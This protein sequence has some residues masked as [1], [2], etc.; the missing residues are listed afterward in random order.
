MTPLEHVCND[1]GQD[2]SLCPEPCGRNH[3]FCS[4]CGRQADPCVHEIPEGTAWK[5]TT[6]SG[7]VHLFEFDQ[8]GNATV[9]RMAGDGAGGLR[10]DG[11]PVPLLMPPAILVGW[12]M[13]MVLDVRGDGVVTERTTTP[14]VS[15]EVIDRA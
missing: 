1:Q 11:G 14:V 6:R 7:S 9:T 12:P 2:R 4:A 10:R 8:A 5:V 15:I 13:R 3:L